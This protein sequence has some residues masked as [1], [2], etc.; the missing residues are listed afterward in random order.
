MPTTV[1][2]VVHVLVDGPAA[3]PGRRT[4]EACRLLGVALGRIEAGEAEG[5]ASDQAGRRRVRWRAV[6][7]LGPSG[8]GRAA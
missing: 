1:R 2:L 8:G 3:E 7:R 4:A 6:W 5:E